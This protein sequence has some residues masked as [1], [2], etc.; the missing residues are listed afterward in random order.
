MSSQKQMV[1]YTNEDAKDIHYYGKL[2]EAL[3]DYELM[4][5][6]KALPDD[7]ILEIKAYV[8]SPYKFM[9]EFKLYKCPTFIKTW[10]TLPLTNDM[11]EYSC[12]RDFG[13][14]E[15]YITPYDSCPGVG[16]S[17]KLM[18]QRL[19]PNLKYSNPT[20][21]YSSNTG[22]NGNPYIVVRSNRVISDMRNVKH[23]AQYENRQL[24]K[25]LQIKGRTK[26][27]H[28]PKADII[29]AILKGS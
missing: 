26:L 9:A 22:K 15:N 1:S 8:I 11:D 18:V 3:K 20:F 13:D 12:Y 29:T 5:G 19:Q 4:E 23:N 7:M 25:D 2:R 24:L 10:R 17:S 14:D 21:K 16:F 27:I 6:I 28:E